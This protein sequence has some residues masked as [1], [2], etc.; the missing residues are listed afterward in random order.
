MFAGIIAAAGKGV[1]RTMLCH[2]D[3]IAD[4]IPVDMVINIMLVA[5]WKVAASKS[6]EIPVYNCCTGRCGTQTERNAN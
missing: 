1:F 5:A 3:K 4:L 6:K 2:P